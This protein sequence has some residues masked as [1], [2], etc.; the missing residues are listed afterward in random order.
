MASPVIVYAEKQNIYDWWRLRN[1]TAPAE[2]QA[3]AS[4]TTMVPS[5]ERLFYVYR[6][7]LQARE[8]F[9]KNC[10]TLEETIVLGCYKATDGIYVF[11]V[12]DTRLQGVKEVTAAH[13][14]LH[15]A[16]DRL[17]AQ[18]RTR[19]DELTA[20]AFANLQDERIKKN[21]ASYR[22]RDPA[23]VPNELHSILATE[24]RTLPEELETY[25]K[26]YFTDRAKIVAYSE[27]YEAEFTSRETARIAY[28]A[29][30]K[31]LKASIDALESSLVARSLEIDQLYAQL[32]ALRDARQYEQYN[33][34]VSP[35]Q[36]KVAAFNADVVK[37]RSLVAQYNQIVEARNAVAG[38]EQELMNA[39]NSAV[40]TTK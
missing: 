33:A 5:A 28:D 19:I 1:Y 24:V 15:A 39:I 27:Q 37:Q 10:T 23:V 32:V 36:A 11:N 6:P 2:V 14:M 26:R 25:Y 13:E 31:D 18:E 29:Q 3:L 17:S 4:R 16:Y 20:Q 8:D 30:L 22:S 21:I 7:S 9:N 12:T 38:E 34:G 40:T 35:Y